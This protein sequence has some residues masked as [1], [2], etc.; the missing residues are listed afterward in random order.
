MIFCKN[1][2]GQEQEEQGNEEQNEH[3]Y[4]EENPNEEEMNQSNQQGENNNRTEDSQREE[5]NENEHEQEHEHFEENERVPLLFVDVNLGHGR[6]ERIIVYE[7][8]RPDELAQR[9][10]EEHGNYFLV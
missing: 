1:K 6:T 5:D 2:L 4:I 3:D 9:F 10:S 7:G 8:D